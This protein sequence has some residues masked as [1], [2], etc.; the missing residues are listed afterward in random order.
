VRGPDPLYEPNELR[1]DL[2]PVVVRDVE[3]GGL[4]A[5]L[6]ESLGA[7]QDGGVVAVVA[8]A[9]AAATAATAS[10]GLVLFVFS[11]SSTRFRPRRLVV[12][13]RLPG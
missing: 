9:A 2:C 11:S 10:W 4:S 1:L 6:L 7:D 3:A 8:A 5:V 12:R 13:R